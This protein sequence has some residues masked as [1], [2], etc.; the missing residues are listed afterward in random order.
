M[1]QLQISD[2]QGRKLFQPVTEG[3]IV[4]ALKSIGG[5]K[6]PEIDGFSAKFFEK[7]WKLLGPVPCLFYE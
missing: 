6:A 4:A 3:E 7:T 1:I 5:N 2:E